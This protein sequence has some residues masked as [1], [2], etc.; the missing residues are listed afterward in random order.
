M[1]WLIISYGAYVI[2]QNTQR[3]YAI[4]QNQIVDSFTTGTRPVPNHF[5]ISN[6]TFIVVNSGGFSGDGSIAFIRNNN[7]IYELLLPSH[8]NPMQ[9]VKVNNKLYFTDFGNTFN[10]KVYI[11]QNY[12]IVDSITVSKRPDGIA[13][14]FGYIFVASTGINSDYSYDDTSSVHR[15][16]PSNNN[17]TRI[18]VRSNAKSIK[19]DNNFVYVMTAG[20]Y[21]NWQSQNNSTIYKIEPISFTIID[22]TRNLENVFEFAVGNNYIFAG[23][24]KFDSVKVYK[25]NKNDF[26]QIDSFKLNFGGFGGV[27]YD[28]EYF[29]FSLGGFT[30]GSNAIYVLR[31]SDNFSYY[32]THHNNDVGS[33]YIK[34]II[35]NPVS[36]QERYLVKDGV[37]YFSKEEFIEVYEVSGRKILQTK[38]NRLNINSLGTG[39]YIIKYS[40]GA[41]RVFAP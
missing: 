13:Y 26:N 9:I 29:K 17:T 37:I 31:E 36:I 24:W 2:G 25:I 15:I 30:G 19:C 20:T 39:I 33:G 12:N 10:N 14:C 38:A 41:L 11:I 21:V 28:G 27:D 7:I 4:Y 3:I 5:I 32:Y 8:M 1:T 35:G 34:A 40:N 16:N 22:S 6:D 23:V 18:R